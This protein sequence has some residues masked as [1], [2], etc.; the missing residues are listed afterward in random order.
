MTV[1]KFC[2]KTARV[3]PGV[4][5]RMLKHLL[6]HLVQKCRSSL[7]VPLTLYMPS[8]ASPE[9]IRKHSGLYATI[10][11]YG[12][13]WE[14]R[15]SEQWQMRLQSGTPSHS[16]W[17]LPQQHAP[18]KVSTAAIWVVEGGAVAYSIGGADRYED[19]KYPYME[20]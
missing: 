3:L 8:S 12:A 1:V 18:L 14:R 9:T 2:R 4:W 20:G 15:Q 5:F 11:A 13:E 16:N 7:F 10:S 19:K 17:K 6:P